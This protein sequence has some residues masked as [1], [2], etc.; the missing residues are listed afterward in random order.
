MKILYVLSGTSLSGG[1]TKSFLYL[2]R[3]MRQH[4]AQVAVA[5]PDKKGVYTLLK[6]IGVEVIACPYTF[7]IWPRTIKSLVAKPL[8]L[9]QNAMATIRLIW[10]ARKWCPDLV[11]SNTSV[12]DVGYLT[13]KRLGVPHLWHIREYGDKDFGLKIIGLGRRLNACG[14]Y[15]IT[16]TRDIAAH[17]GIMGKCT[18]RV[19]YNG[20]IDSVMPEFESD[21]QNYFLY[22]GRVEPTKGLDD[23]VHAFILYSKRLPRNI[24]DLKIAGSVDKTGVKMVRTLKNEIDE[25]GLT[26]RVEWLGDRNDISTLMRRALAVVV[27]SHFEGFG[28]VMPEAMAVGTIVIGRNTGGTREQMENGLHI[29]GKEIALSFNNINELT[30]CL[31]RVSTT[32]QS[33]FDS[34][35]CRAAKTIEELYT[36]GAYGSQV[37]KFYQEILHQ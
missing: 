35:R 33:D 17:H 2:V 14:N 18:N 6:K 11:H 26:A 19:I 25:A 34:M 24:T 22:A 5:T 12:N 21:R 16:I 3:Y 31:I 13:A 23:L 29:T 28:R 7:N 10:F 15:S 1:A 27:P 4:G 8:R 32:A 37:L 9:I 30:D 20:I 36:T